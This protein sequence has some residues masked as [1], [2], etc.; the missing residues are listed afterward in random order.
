VAETESAVARQRDY[1][2]RTA[3]HYEAMH[4][5]PDD[6]HGLALAAFAGIARLLGAGSVLDV[7]AGTG[8]ALARLGSELPG[9]RLLGVEPVAELRA[10]GHAQGIP[11]DRLVEG[12]ACALP[13]ADDSFDFVIETGMLHHLPDPAKAVREMMRVARL[14]VMLSD[15]NKFGQGSWPLRLAK[16]AI[17]RLGVWNTAIWLS[18]GGRMAKWSEGDGQFW[19]YSVF[20]NQRQ[21]QAKFPRLHWLNTAALSGTDLKRGTAS[22][23]VVALK[24]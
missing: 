1:Y 8:R 13:F 22:I 18:T 7:G 3:A 20:D 16:A 2:A 21:L 14:G 6:E 10:V 9:C 15:S 5:R 12:D 24:D 19:S 4:V 23:A 11:A 17:G